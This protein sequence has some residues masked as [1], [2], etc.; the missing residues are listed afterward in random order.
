MTAS[1]NTPAAMT[2]SCQVVL[3]HS[4]LGVRPAVRDWA[5]QLR[6]AGHVVHVPDLYEGKT[7]DEHEEGMRHVESI[8]GIQ[9]LVARTIAAAGELP[10]NVVYA[11]F[12]NGAASAEL[13]AAT[14]P[15]AR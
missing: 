3:F 6:A 11:G 1:P 13:L 10:A 12:S 14:R 5:D 2:T 15:G 8:G 7:F 4:V 9:T